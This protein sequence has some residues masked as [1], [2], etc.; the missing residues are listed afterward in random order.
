[1]V[2]VPTRQV[3]FELPADQIGAGSSWVW[4][5]SFSSPHILLS[6]VW[7]SDRDIGLGVGGGRGGGGGL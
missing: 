5:S 3:T 7:N 6:F 2:F 4:E 1:M